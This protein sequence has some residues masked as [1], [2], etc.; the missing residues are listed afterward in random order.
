[1][2]GGTRYCLSFLCS[3]VEPATGGAFRQF[4][5]LE[6]S[7]D[8]KTARLV[9]A[10]LLRNPPFTLLWLDDLSPA[11]K[12]QFESVVAHHE[13]VDFNA[14]SPA[15]RDRLDVLLALRGL[16]A[17]G[18]LHSRLT[19]RHAI[20]YGTRPGDKSLAVPYRSARTPSERAEFAD[21]DITVILTHLAWYFE[22]LSRTAF[23]DTLASLKKKGVSAQEDI[24]SMCLARV[25]P[26]LAPEVLTRIDRV[27]KL[28]EDD[29]SQMELLFELFHKNP[30][31]INVWLSDI[32]LPRDTSQ[33]PQT[34]TANAWHLAAMPHVV[35]FSGTKENRLLLPMFVEMD[36]SPDAHVRATDGENLRKIFAA[37]VCATERIESELELLDWAAKNAQCLIDVGGLMSSFDNRD[38]ALTLLKR[39][40][41]PAS[42]QGVVFYEKEWK[43]LLRSGVVS[44]LRESPVKEKDAFVFFDEAQCRGVDMRL[45]PDACGVLTLGRK[46]T[47]DKLCQAACRL[48]LLG[49]GQ[50]LKIVAFPDVIAAVLRARRD[51]F[52]V[53]AVLNWT[54][55]NANDMVAGG[56][57]QWAAQGNY[58]HES[59][60]KP[61][62][63]LRQVD[64]DLRNLF[65]GARKRL[66]LVDHVREVVSLPSA[67]HILAH[68]TRYGEGVELHASAD[69][70]CERENEQE[71]E[72]EQQREVE[73]AN[74]VPQAESNFDLDRLESPTC[75]HFGQPLSF[76]ED[77]LG[78]EPGIAWG[79][80]IFLTEN[81]MKPIEDATR[82]MRPVQGLLL[83]PD[84]SILL[85]SE[86]EADAVLAHQ[87]GR[88][89]FR[90]AAFIDEE[91]TVS[92]DD[93]L[94]LHLLRGN[95]Q[96]CLF[97]NHDLSVLSKK[98]ALDSAVKL[99]ELQGNRRALE[100]SALDKLCKRSLFEE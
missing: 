19:K 44:S 64:Y 2:V 13:S 98:T 51:D 7:C 26:E 36:A 29:N 5:F 34:L 91:V 33:Y 89:L 99:V 15:L 70:E 95:P 45:R 65:G 50:T 24:Y 20:D 86:R 28:E 76:F 22:G 81:F 46:M 92:L 75:R 74:M 66:T 80:N 83:Y 57:G 56:L 38:V 14:L 4:R 73:V 40:Q 54:F 94:R 58:F 1:M 77:Y 17:F 96:S 60:E 8:K 63:A 32:V 35:G 49:R 55:A 16:L 85:L 59:T 90:H 68:V 6:P 82:V 10:E 25:A 72:K 53:A 52:S 100:R 88:R 21:A 97:D 61:E 37:A 47:R 93:K 39:G 69:N 18:L 3:K 48:R 67:S 43:F 30:E 62:T 23:R 41:L 87:K 12:A 11:N 31:F 79:S 9:A 78:V 27:A 84:Q 71:E 42:S